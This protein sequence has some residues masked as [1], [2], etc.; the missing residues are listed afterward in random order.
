MDCSTSLRS[1]E[2]LCLL[3]VIYMPFLVIRLY[4]PISVLV[5]VSLARKLVASLNGL[6]G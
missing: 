2:L 3:L 6:S 1:A 4:L 5:N